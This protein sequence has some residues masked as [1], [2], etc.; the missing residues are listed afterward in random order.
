[1]AQSFRDH[2]T[3][4]FLAEGTELEGVLQVKGGIRIDGKVKGEIQSESVIYVGDQAVI[5]ANIS[6]EGVISSG[7]ITGDIKTGQQVMVSV[8]GSIKGAIETRELILEKGV[9]FDGTCTLVD[10]K[11]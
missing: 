2:K 1:M 9:Y 3:T 11:K 7:R 5:D 4:S 10:S 8:P 6:A